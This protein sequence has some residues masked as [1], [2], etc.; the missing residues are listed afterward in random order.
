MVKKKVKKLKSGKKG[1]RKPVKKIVKKTIKKKAK[2]SKKNNKK[3]HVGPPKIKGEKIVGKIEHFFDKLSV[4][5]I[6]VTAPF[7]VGDFLHIKGH[8]TDFYQ[9]VESIQINHQNVAKVKKGDDVGI[10]SKDFVREHDW[11]FLAPQAEKFLAS[12]PVST[13]IRKSPAV[14]V[15][16]GQMTIFDKVPAKPA[17]ASTKPQILPQPPQKDGK[18]DPYQGTK[19]LK[20]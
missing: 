15:S 19:F 11:V 5:I 8:T 2:L 16:A 7:K 10:K 20:F 12:K 3:L 6:N 14:K 17:P 13:M 18:P 9:K 4:A 1:A